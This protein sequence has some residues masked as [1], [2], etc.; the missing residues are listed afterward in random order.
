MAPVPAP[1]GH[2]FRKYVLYFATLVSASLLLSGGIQLY[3]SYRE[4]R[5]A[6]VALQQ[7]TATAAA[8]RIQNYISEIEIHVGW[9]TLPHDDPT[10]PEQRRADYLRL[11]RQAPA[12]TEA[13]LIGGD[14]REQLRVSRLGLD[15]VDS[16]A[17]F[18]RDPSFTEARI[19]RTYFGPVYFRQDTEPYMTLSVATGGHDASVTAVDINLT[20]VWDVVLRIK[21]GDTGYAYVVDE[22]GQL[23]SHPDISLVLQKL[24]LSML[25]QVSAVLT[26]PISNRKYA[27]SVGTDTRGRPVVAAAAAIPTLGWTVFVERPHTEALAPLYSSVW[28]TGMLLIVGLVLSVAAA[29]LLA[30]RMVT[31]IRALQAGATRLGAGALDHRIEIATGDELEALAKQFNQMASQLEASY[32]HLE[33]RIGERT[34]ELELASTAKSRFLAAASHDLRQPMHALGLFVARL[35]ET[36]HARDAVHTIEQ[37]EASVRALDQLLDALLDISRLDAGVLKPRLEDFQVQPLLARMQTEFLPAAQ[38]KGLRLSVMPSRLVVRSD[39][40]LLE[41]I[42]MNLMSN[43]VRYTS[44]GGIIVGARRREGHA[45]LEIWDS[46]PG[47]PVEKQQAIFQEFYQLGNPERDRS[48]GLGLGLAIVKRLA[49]L[50]E[51]PLD[52]TSSPG[53]GSRFSIELPLGEARRVTPPPRLRKPPGDLSGAFVVVVEDERLVREGMQDL[54]TQWGCQVVTAGSAMEA[55]ARLAEHD[56]IPDLIIS[57]YRLRDGETGIQAISRLQA[58]YPVSIPALLISGDTAPERLREARESGLRLLHKPV[59]PAR[60][61]AMLAAL[62]AGNDRDSAA[63]S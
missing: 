54:L 60:L 42:L 47:I 30:R 23:V 5:A 49:Q 41:R 2:L 25:P 45:R 31:P 9:T 14:G 10:A 12:V 17:D 21:V 50:L 27:L 61:R 4:N 29:V 22:T 36:V 57:D 62:L 35:R 37:I 24:N 46:G 8:A 28:R 38:A 20:F 15:A 48:K 44:L 39:P 3:V 1:S 52:L 26:P 63:A 40:V 56:R 16:G 55:A 53:R 43:A 32:A 34:R 7:E 33:Q 18:S 59:P 51:H 58:E 19:G 6:L 13:R 11:L